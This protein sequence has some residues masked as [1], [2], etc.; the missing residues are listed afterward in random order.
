MISFR[1]SDWLFIVGIFLNVFL[2][3]FSFLTFD[4]Y[5]V[6]L[7]IFCV[8]CFLFSYRMNLEVEDEKKEEDK[9]DN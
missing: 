3:A 5:G 4:Y 9:K 2:F 7:S 8:G 1:F 6:I